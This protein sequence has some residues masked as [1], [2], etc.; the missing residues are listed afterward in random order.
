MFILYIYFSFFCFLASKEI[1]RAFT[2][3]IVRTVKCYCLNEH[4]I[5]YID[6]SSEKTFLK[7]TQSYAFLVI[8]LVCCQGMNTLDSIILKLV[9]CKTV[10]PGTQSSKCQPDGG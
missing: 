2:P 8:C 4:L 5:L 3:K 7:S 6:P 1:H 9:T 10:Y